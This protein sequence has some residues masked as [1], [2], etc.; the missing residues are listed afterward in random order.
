MRGKGVLREH[1]HRRSSSKK[2]TLNAG[3]VKGRPEN[4]E[5]IVLD[6]DSDI[7]VNP[8]ESSKQQFESYNVPREDK[9]LSFEGVITIDDDEDTDVD[10]GI[11]VDGDGDLVSDASSSKSE[12][13]AFRTV[14]NSMNSDIDECRIIWEK[15]SAF[16]FSKCKQTYCTKAPGRNCY[17][18]DPASDN[19]STDSDCSDCELVE[20]SFI[21]RQQW[22]RASLRRKHDLNHHS[23]AEDQTSASGSN[24]DVHA[25]A[26]EENGR[27]EQ[28]P[29]CSSSSNAAY[30]KENVSEFFASD[31]GYAETTSFKP[32]SDGSFMDYHKGE[33][34]S[35]PSWK[36]VSVQETESFHGNAD[37]H[38]EGCTVAGDPRC[39]CNCQSNKNVFAGI[40]GYG[41]EAEPSPQ[42]SFQPRGGFVAED[43]N[44]F[45]NG[46]TYKNVRDDI[47][48]F[49]NVK[50]PCAQGSP[51][52]WFEQEAGGKQYMHPKITSKGKEKID[53]GQSFVSNSRLFDEVPVDNGVSLPDDKFGDGP[54]EFIFCRTSVEG[55]LEGCSGK[56]SYQDRASADSNEASLRKTA[57]N[58]TN[59]DCADSSI[60]EAKEPN[61]KSGLLDPQAGNGT[62]SVEGNLINEREKLKDTDE[63]KRAID[64]EWAA[65]QRELQIQSEEAQRLRKRRKA[66]TMRLCDIERRQK[67]RIEEVRET[68]KKDEENINLKEKL[69]G[70]IRQEISRLE[71]TCIDMASLLR[72]LGIQVAGGFCPMS[73]DVHAAY[74]RALLKFHPDRASKTDIRQQVEAEEKFKLISRMKE[75]FLS[76]SCY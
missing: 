56:A 30:Q 15:A 49:C 68:Q 70:E 51:V 36:P 52:M 8:V 48:G 3:K 34:E 13:P 59:F 40:S 7:T 63:Y 6:D 21:L 29:V 54:E 22:Q 39:G 72:G 69:R 35:F 73:H 37:F 60:L 38:P 76:T 65:R 27:E 31:G 44:C 62:L 1:S 18:L 74:K 16:Q 4:V 5:F 64:E 41:N 57:S 28:V 67:Q 46:K 17:G 66:E 50:E 53:P 11:C 25:N 55:N 32:A 47:P 71:I 24:G 10:L 26:D 75:K 9:K 19:G 14:R 2:K 20:D 61:D 42:E 45:Y 23:G 12:C 43:P 33:R 58:Q